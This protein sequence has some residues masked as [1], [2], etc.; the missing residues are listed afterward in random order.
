MINYYESIPI[1]K[2]NPILRAELCILWKMSD[3]QVR[4]T[5][6]KLRSQDNGDDFVIVSTSDNAGYYRSDDRLDINKFKQQTLKRGKR[7]FLPLKKVNR[8][9]NIHQNQTSINNVLKMARIEAQLT[10]DEVVK[11]LCKVD[12][13]FDKSLLSRIEN[14]LCLPTLNQIAVLTTLYNQPINDLIGIY[15]QN[16]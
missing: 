9:L 8:I 6:A 10:T 15:T 5:V 12:V 14:G 16:D 1:G 7:T 13:R 2:D 3:R 4:N 11:E